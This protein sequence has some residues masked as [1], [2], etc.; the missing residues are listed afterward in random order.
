MKSALSVICTVSFDSR[1]LSSMW[2]TTAILT[3]NLSL[4]DPMWSVAD[5]LIKGIFPNVTCDHKTEKEE[6]AIYINFYHQTTEPY[7]IRRKFLASCCNPFEAM[8]EAY[9]SYRCYLVLMTACSLLDYFWKNSQQ[10]QYCNW[11]ILNSLRKI[12][13]YVHF[14]KTTITCDW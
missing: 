11:N 14:T 7:E 3:G 6:T 10:F 5:I 9:W 13:F 1:I 2:R 12:H 4:N 8:C